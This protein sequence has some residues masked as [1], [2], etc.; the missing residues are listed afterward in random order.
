MRY[1]VIVLHSE[2]NQPVA[3]LADEPVPDWA[4]DLVHADDLVSAGGEADEGYSSMKVDALKAEIATRNEGRDEADQLSGE[5]KK[6]DL[7]AVLEADD[8]K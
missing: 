6:A 8:E 4:S 3:L 1:T 2:T 7:I 5:G